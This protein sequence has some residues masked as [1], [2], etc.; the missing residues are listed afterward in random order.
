[1]R[2]IT[3]SVTATKQL[4]GLPAGAREQI[5]EKIHRYAE[6]GAGQVKAL[7]GRPGVRLRVGRYRVV[8]TELQNEILVLAVG[9]RRDIYR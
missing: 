3:Y 9:D 7:A 6:T 2:R 1:M 8:F 4:R 5:I